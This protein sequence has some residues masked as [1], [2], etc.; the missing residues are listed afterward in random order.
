M[1]YFFF[2]LFLLPIILVP[3]T[4]YT[5]V[6]GDCLWFIAERFYNNPFLWPMIYE[7]NKDKI[8]DPHWIYPDQVFVIPNYTGGGIPPVVS[9]VETPKNEISKEKSEDS[10]IIM[11]NKPMEEQKTYEPKPIKIEQKV[12]ERTFTV[13][14]IKNEIFSKESALLAGF[15]TERKGLEKGR[16]IEST[17]KEENIVLSAKVLIDKGNMDGIY[18]KDRFAIFRYGDNVKGFGNIVRILGVVEIKETKERSSIGEIIA[19]FEPIHK[20]DLIFDIPQFTPPQNKIT[21]TLDNITGYIIAFKDKS[22]IVKPY[23]IAYITPGAPH[24]KPGDL[25]LIYRERKVKG[26]SGVAPIEPIGQF[27]V[28]EPK[29]N[30]T[31]SGYIITTYDKIDIKVGDKVRLVGR[32]VGE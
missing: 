23:S 30:R 31:A 12:F 20:N 21:P 3:Q 29:N 15:I 18:V 13:V 7:A 27:L 2:F 19:S 26:L 4:T 10:G 14:G 6:K 24:V 8:K 5:V 11:T 28:I 22:D 17:T 1:R 9:N 25:F 16:I 32:A